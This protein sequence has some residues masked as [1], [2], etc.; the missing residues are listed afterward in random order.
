M[1]AQA[2]GVLLDERTLLGHHGP[3]VQA[4][5]QRHGVD[6]QADH[7]FGTGQL[8][9]PGGY[10]DPKDHILAVG[11]DRQQQRPSQLGQRIYRDAAA[12]GALNQTSPGGLV[13][14][15]FC[16]CGLMVWMCPVV[17]EWHCRQQSGPLQAGKMVPP[18]LFTLLCVAAGQPTDVITEWPWWRWQRIDVAAGFVQL[19]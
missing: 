2:C 18:L 5:A 13:E 12:A 14:A 8:G 11:Q 10:R 16:D 15:Q 19:Q 7:R 17:A 4:H 3:W 6:Q 1:L 9:G